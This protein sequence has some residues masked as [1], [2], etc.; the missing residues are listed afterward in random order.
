M[1]KLVLNT[2]TNEWKWSRLLIRLVETGASYIQFGF[3][4][5]S[6]DTVYYGVILVGTDIG[7][8]MADEKVKVVICNRSL[9]IVQ[10]KF[11]DINQLCSPEDFIKSLYLHIHQHKDKLI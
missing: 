5:E 6:L 7:A 9:I 11:I 3:E 10:V 1:K 8:D 4:Y 2:K